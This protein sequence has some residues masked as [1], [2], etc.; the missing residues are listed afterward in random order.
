M[1]HT[2]EKQL[3]GPPTKLVFDYAFVGKKMYFIIT[4]QKQGVN[5]LFC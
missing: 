1:A 5:T 4:R 2:N 3:Y